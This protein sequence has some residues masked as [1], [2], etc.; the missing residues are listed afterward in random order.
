MYVLIRQDRMVVPY[1]PVLDI[2]DLAKE[3]YEAV[4][5]FC[6]SRIGADHAADVAQETFLAAQ[7]ALPNFGGES[8]VKTWLLGIAHNRCRLHFRAER[9][10]P[11]SVRLVPSEEPAG[12]SPE[13]PLIDRQVLQQA[14]NRLSPEHREVV[15]LHAGDGLTYDE[16]ATVLG[17]PAGTVKSRLHHAFAQMRR[18]LEGGLA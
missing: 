18:A 6:A 9:Q 1:R 3:H 7:K 15:L 5:R 17:I 8:S 11:V 10:E 14:L 16:A 12:A 4:F 2:R 13:K